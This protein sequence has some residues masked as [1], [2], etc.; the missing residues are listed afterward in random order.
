MRFFDVE[1]SLDYYS[2]GMLM[3]E[4]FGGGD[5]R[6]GYQGSEKDNE[7]KG[8]GNSYTTHFR[9]LDPRLGRWLTIDPKASSLPWQSPYCSMDNNPILLNDVLGDSTYNQKSTG[10]KNVAIIF[11]N[12]DEV[13]RGLADSWKGNLALKGWDYIVTDNEAEAENWLYKN[14]KSESISTLIVRQHSVTY[15]YLDKNGVKQVLPRSG[16]QSVAGKDGS[17]S[18]QE[19]E[20]DLYNGKSETK[21]INSYRK[22]G[23]YISPN[24]T[25]VLT[26]CHFAVKLVDDP[27]IEI[28]GKELLRGDPL[29]KQKIKTIHRTLSLKP[30]VSL[31]I[32]SN[33]TF[34]F[35][36]LNEGSGSFSSDFYSDWGWLKIN[37]S[38]IIGFGHD[39]KLGK[40]GI[41]ETKLNPND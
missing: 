4:R 26:A 9:Q 11:L 25:M 18:A 2:F 39:L 34:G 37:G 38:G 23:S 22:F 21:M 35:S 28:N 33:S 24:G 27:L 3:P 20:K 5:Y 6:Y 32:N 10:S 41:E 16:L 19:L 8:N 40:N 31:F 14:Y 30:S 7:V 12:D 29:D 15:S 17:V 1:N 13:A 36:V